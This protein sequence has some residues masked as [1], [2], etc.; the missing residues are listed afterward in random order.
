MLAE[1]KKPQR[2][3]AQEYL[4]MDP[5]PSWA[6]SGEESNAMAYRKS[7]VIFSQGDPA[8]AVYYV[9]KGKVKLSVFSRQGKEAVIAILESGDFLGESCLAGQALRT[10]SATAM[11]DSLVLRLPK[12]SAI[13]MLQEEH[14]FSRMFISHLLAR[15]VRIEED[16]VDH[17]FNS[18]E[19]RLARALLLLANFGRPGDSGPALI[20]NITQEVLAE[21]VGTTRP[22]ISFF[23]N[24]FRKLGFIQYSGRR[25]RVNSSL[26]T[27]VLH[28]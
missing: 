22:R 13:R 19:K 16:L 11:S 23:L 10:A 18:S 21:M 4:R 14:A 15:N 1:R 26:L 20:L 28:D 25:L 5:K 6:R 2:Q 7:Q 12:A 9:Q 24:K 3:E 17:L 27:V 8:D